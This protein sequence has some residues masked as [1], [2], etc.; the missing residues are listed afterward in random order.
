MNNIMIF[1]FSD[2]KKRPARPCAFCGQYQT[3]L[4][5]HL[6]RM[7]KDESEVELASCFIMNAKFCLHFA[8][9]AY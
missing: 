8:I 3:Q 6:F 1:L 7:H 5:R 2:K 4:A 9:F